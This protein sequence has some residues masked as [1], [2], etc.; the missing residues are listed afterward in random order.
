MPTGRAVFAWRN[1]LGDS[2]AVQRSTG[3]EGT[4]P[5][6]RVAPERTLGDHLVRVVKLLHAMRARLADAHPGVDPLAFPLLFRIAHEPCRVSDLAAAFHG[7]VSTIS[8]Q[9]STFVELGLVEREADPR[10]GRAHVLAP[11][12]EGLALLARIRGRR[13]DF[14]DGLLSSWSEADRADFARMLERLAD[15]LEQHTHDT[16]T[17]ELS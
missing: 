10:D 5:A 1:H 13:D 12:A 17:Q 7:E 15:S 14:I 9:V 11:T 3:A 2:C 4:G 16:A 6:T 8:R